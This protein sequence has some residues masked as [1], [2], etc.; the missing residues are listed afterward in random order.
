MNKLAPTVTLGLGVTTFMFLFTYLP[1][2]AV[3]TFVEGPLAPLSTILLVLSESSTL[4]NALSKNFLI[5]DALVDT[6]DGTLVSKNMT[7]IVAEGRQVKSGSDPI[8]KLG[9][10]EKF[11]KDFEGYLVNYS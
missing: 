3:L 2:A 11:V 10:C 7:G 6:F 1:Q 8:A 9:K 5:A 4:F